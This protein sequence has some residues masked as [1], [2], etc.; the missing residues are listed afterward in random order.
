MVIACVS[1]EGIVWRRLAPYDPN[2]GGLALRDAG[3]DVNV[4]PQTRLRQTVRDVIHARSLLRLAHRDL[5]QSLQVA[6]F[7]RC[8]QRIAPE[9]AGILLP[10]SSHQN[11]LEQH[12]GCQC[13]EQC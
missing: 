13:A 10:R 2:M 9:R 8:W 7:C 11:R 5:L 3:R 1:M 4:R 12:R 6:L